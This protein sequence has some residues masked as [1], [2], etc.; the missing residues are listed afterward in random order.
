MVYSSASRLALPFQLAL[1][2]PLAATAQQAAPV[3]KVEVSGVASDYDARKYDTAAKIVIRADAL[4]QFGDTSIAEALKRQ[5]GMTV[6]RGNEIRMRGLG[7]GYT[8]VLVDGSPLPPG[9]S[10]DSVSPQLIDRVEIMRAGGADLGGQGIAGTVNIILKKAIKPGQKEFKINA[11]GN[12]AFVSTVADGSISGKGERISYVLAGRVSAGTFDQPST[13]LQ[14]DGAGRRT[15]TGSDKGNGRSLVLT[16]RLVWNPDASNAV[17]VKAFVNVNRY[18][19]TITNVWDAGLPALE[20]ARSVSTQRQLRSSIDWTRKLGASKLEAKLDGSAGVRDSDVDQLG[21]GPVDTRQWDRSLGFT[22]KYS[23]P[24]AEGHTLVG[25]WDLNRSVGR[26]RRQEL[27]GLQRHSA[28]IGRATLFLQDD[29]VI[30]QQWSAYFGANWASLVTDADGSDYAPV[31][32]RT[33]RWSP[34]FQVLWKISGS[35]NDQLRLGLTRSYK[36]PA[37]DRM[38]PR[39][40]VSPVNSATRPDTKGNPALREE[41]ANGVD[42]AFEHIV[43]K[44][45][46]FSISGYVRRIDGAVSRDLALI[47]DRWVSQPVNQGRARTH[48]ME[49]ETKFMLK[50]YLAQAPAIDVRL[51]LA[52]NWSSVDWVSG[53]DNRL[54]SQLPYSASVGLDYRAGERLSGGASF[55]LRGGGTTRLDAR[56]QKRASIGRELDLYALWHMGPTTKLRLS[57][58]NVL[59]QDFISD[60]LYSG[61]LGAIRTTVTEQVTP[62][63]RVQLELK[64]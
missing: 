55:A 43:D 16:P 6:G 32:Q 33:S 15:S 19:K 5:P 56:Q 64:L 9:F 28:A 18:N 35:A 45:P 13:T 29:W 7:N 2:L 50:H 58:V 48:G 57:A 63:L 40:T 26:E 23:A 21:L 34:V 22:G 4:N 41:V 38:L 25:G 31:R 46:M 10:L 59:G 24:A 52:R 20:H 60:E 42:L 17:G 27:S 51:N 49:V 8:Q 12:N 14:D 62:M 36:A 3:P 37:V 1:A 11:A 44:G 54:D 61:D 39:L 47:G 30:D 53:P